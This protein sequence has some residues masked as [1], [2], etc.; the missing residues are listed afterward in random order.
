M[1]ETSFQYGRHKQIRAIL[2]A[3]FHTNTKRRGDEPKTE[4][5][6]KKKESK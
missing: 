3:P 6:Q 5:K 1:E 4:Q 2:S